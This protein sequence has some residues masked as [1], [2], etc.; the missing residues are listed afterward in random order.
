MTTDTHWLSPTDFVS[1]DKSLKI[2]YP[3]VTHSAV[4]IKTRALGDLKWIYLGLRVP[5]DHD[6]HAIHVCYQLSNSR[7]FISQVRL[8]EMQTPDQT[9][10]RHDDGTNLLST[11]PT[12]YRSPVVAFRPGAAVL[13]A[14][15]LNFGNAADTITLGAVG[16]EALSSCSPVPS[17]TRSALPIPVA[18]GCLARVADSERGLWMGTGSVD[19]GDGIGDRNQWFNLNAE[20]NVK[21]FGA[22]GDGVTDDLAAFNAAIAA[23]GPANTP[24]LGQT[25]YVPP[26]TYYLSNTLHITR[27]QGRQGVTRQARGHIL[28]KAGKGSH[29]VI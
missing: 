7:S 10:V 12:C 8:V 5:P 26:G 21:D 27:R 20:I 28:H 14:L 4:E 1:G 3:S 6:I 9:V 15:R 24:F 17:Y 2:S 23:L 13:L 18:A 16:V 29:L 22:K 19:Y 11:S 25:L